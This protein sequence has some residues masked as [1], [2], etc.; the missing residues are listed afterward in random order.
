MTNFTENQQTRA[1]GAFVQKHLQTFGNKATTYANGRECGAPAK[2]TLSFGAQCALV[3]DVR[4]DIDGVVQV[5][6][7]DVTVRGNHTRLL[8]NWTM[9]IRES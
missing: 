7:V 1:V 8:E 4:R 5:R 9:I 2:V 3:F 6:A